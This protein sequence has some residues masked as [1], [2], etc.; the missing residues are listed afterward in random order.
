INKEHQ[1]TTTTTTK[2]TKF[3][4]PNGKSRICCFAWL[5]LFLSVEHLEQIEIVLNLVV[6]VNKNL[7][8]KKKLTHIGSN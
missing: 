7:N 1:T 5:F 2:K 6:D 4:I 8:Q 3:K